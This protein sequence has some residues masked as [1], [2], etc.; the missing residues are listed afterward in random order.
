[1]EDVL[2]YVSQKTQGLS[3]EL[4]EKNDEMLVDLKAVNTSLDTRNRA[5][6]KT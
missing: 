5:S 1:L 2:S 4:T 6:K 3:K